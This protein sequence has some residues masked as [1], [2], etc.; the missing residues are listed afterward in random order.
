MAIQVGDK[1]P[2]FTL[3]DTENKPVT[4][5]SFAGQKSV[6]L[7][8]IP[9]A[10]TNVCKGELCTLRDNL[11][12]FES[13]DN[14]VLAITCDRSPSLKEWKSQQGYNFPML[15]D[16]WPHGAVAKL[17]GCFNEAVGCADRLTVVVNKEGVIADLFKSGGLGE[18]R[19]FSLYGTALT[20]V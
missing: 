15:S 9:F 19:D 3:R 5:S 13:H 14:A 12:Q 10:F 11:N 4:L 6:T 7:V 20:K 2:D 18:A 1:A 8:F 17:Y 16:G